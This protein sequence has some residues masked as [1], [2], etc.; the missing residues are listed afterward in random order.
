MEN[1][2][3]AQQ[4]ERVFLV[5][6]GKL[7]DLAFDLLSE[8]QILTE[9]PSVNLNFLG[10]THDLLRRGIGVGKGRTNSVTVLYTFQYCALTS[11]FF[12]TI[13]DNNPTAANTDYK[14][15]TYHGSFAGFREETGNA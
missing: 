4:F 15:L 13:H 2:G 9:F 8:S 11:R 14:Q 6:V 5:I 3:C 10:M 7:V 1:D 12:I